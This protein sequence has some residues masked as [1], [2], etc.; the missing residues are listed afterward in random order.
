MN[1]IKTIMQKLVK[2]LNNVLNNI[3]I[4]LSGGRGN[5]VVLKSILKLGERQSEVQQAGKNKRFN[6]K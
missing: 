5:S 3:I 2:V 1:V 4:F 6:Q